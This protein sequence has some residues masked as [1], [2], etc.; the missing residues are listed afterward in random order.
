MADRETLYRQFG[1]KSS[2]ALLTVMWMI[3]KTQIQKINAMITSINNIHGTS[4]NLLEDYNLV[5]YANLYDECLGNVPIY[6]W[7]TNLGG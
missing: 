2:E 7:M 4:I 1:P 6:N 5:D 3:N